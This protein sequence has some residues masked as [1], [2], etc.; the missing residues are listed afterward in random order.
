MAVSFVD[1]HFVGSFGVDAVGDG[2]AEPAGEELFEG[3]PFLIELD[4]SGP[5][6]QGDYAF[7]IVPCAGGI[8]GLRKRD[9]GFD[10]SEPKF[11]LIH[12][13]TGKL[14][15][16]RLVVGGEI[17]RG[18]IDDVDGAKAVAIVGDERRGG[19]KT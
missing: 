17:A 1:A 19:I 10:G 3:D 13:N 11:H 5:S 9:D 6:T 8:E 4:L 15:E 14:A 7:E 12:H 16:G 18:E 2:E